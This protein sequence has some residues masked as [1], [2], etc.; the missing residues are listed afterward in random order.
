MPHATVAD[1]D[2][3]GFDGEAFGL[4]DEAE[5]LTYVDAIIAEAD[6]VIQDRVSDAVYTAADGTLDH[7]RVRRAVTAW[8]AQELYIRLDNRTLQ[9]N[10][11]PSGV[12][13]YPDSPHMKAAK[14]YRVEVDELLDFLGAAPLFGE[15]GSSAAASTVIATSPFPEG[16]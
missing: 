8:V 12:R 11:D 6:L 3:I 16:Q 10:V 4:P 15:G 14:R 1:I 13:F 2:A 5:W 9:T 7:S